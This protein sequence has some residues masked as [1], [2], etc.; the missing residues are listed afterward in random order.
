MVSI[1]IDLC[2]DQRSLFAPGSDF[3]ILWSQCLNVMLKFDN[4]RHVVSKNAAYENGN[5]LAWCSRCGTHS[6]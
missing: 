6:V 3:N 2:F 4:S 5:L 1:H